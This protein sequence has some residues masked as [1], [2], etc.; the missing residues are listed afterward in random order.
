MSGCSGG[1]RVGGCRR[2]GYG[3]EEMIKGE[4]V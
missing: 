2:D 3:L 4:R 1:W